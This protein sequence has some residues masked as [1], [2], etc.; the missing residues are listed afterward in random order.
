MTCSLNNGQKRRMAEISEQKVRRFVRK[1]VESSFKKLLKEQ[2]PTGDELGPYTTLGPHVDQPP[3]PNK[4]IGDSDEPEVPPEY[5]EQEGRPASEVTQL[6]PLGVEVEEKS[7]MES[8][9]ENIATSPNRYQSMEDLEAF[10][11]TDLYGLTNQALELRDEY[12]WD[13]QTTLEYVNRATKVSDLKRRGKWD[14]MLDRSDLMQ[15]DFLPHSRRHVSRG[16]SGLG[17]DITLPVT[18]GRGEHRVVLPAK[19]NQLGYGLIDRLGLDR[20]SKYIY[21]DTPQLANYFDSMSSHTPRSERAARFK[22]GMIVKISSGPQRVYVSPVNLRDSK[23]FRNVFR[24][25]SDQLW[26]RFKRYGGWGMG[27]AP[28]WADQG[29]WMTRYVRE[30][31]MPVREWYN[32]ERFN[33]LTKKW[34]KRS[35]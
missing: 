27:N 22:P 15:T 1:L 8:T 11:G 4:P 19:I 23:V 34:T 32:N 26:S 17:R 29:D 25:E 35:L 21:V 30:P 28:R 16:V 13:D 20:N 5:L 6:S 12:Q 18:M 33:A 10:A 7:E 24:K 2:E 31:A 3:D 9:L 14:L